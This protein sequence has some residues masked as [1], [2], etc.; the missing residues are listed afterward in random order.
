LTNIHFFKV[1]IKIQKLLLFAKYNFKMEQ[2]SKFFK[3]TNEEE[4]NEEED[5]ETDDIIEELSKIPKFVNKPPTANFSTSGGSVKS[6]LKR[7]EPIDWNNYFPN[8]A[9]INNVS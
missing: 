7:Y 5:K 8:S 1:K 9:L 4:I 6:K 3:K 2:K